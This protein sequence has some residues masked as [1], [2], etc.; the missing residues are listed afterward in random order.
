MDFELVSPIERAVPDHLTDSGRTVPTKNTT[1]N[2]GIRTTG[3]CEHSHFLL[4]LLETSQFMCK[5]GIRFEQF[6][7]CSGK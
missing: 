3:K 4:S 1:H 5:G 7:A 2:T 6:I